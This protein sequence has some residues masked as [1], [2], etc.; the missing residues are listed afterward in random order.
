MKIN[1]RPEID[2]L[3]AIAVISVILFHAGSNLFSGGYVGVDIFFVISGFLITN[4]ILIELQKGNFSII[5]FYERRAR[6]ILPLLFFVMTLSIPFAW[7]LLP[8]SDLQNFSKSLIAATFFLSNLFFWKEGGGYFEIAS[9]LKPLVHT[10]S[11]AIEAQYYLFFPLLLIFIYKLGKKWVLFSIYLVIICSLL[12]AQVG[13]IYRPVANFFLLPTR[14]WEFAIGSLVV[15]LISNKHLIIFSSKLKSLL[16][17][18]GLLLII[19]AIFFFNKETAFT[20]FY[21][22]IPTIGAALIILFASQDNIVGRFLSEKKIVFIGLISYSLYIWHLPILAFSRYYFSS[23]NTTHTIVLIL[24]TFFLSAITWRFIERPFRNNN[25]FSRN[26]IFI[27]S[28]IVSVFFICFGFVSFKVFSSHSSFGLE[29][30][31]AKI[32]AEGNIVYAP[33]V[34]EREFIK[35]RIQFEKINPN[36]IVLGSSRTM[37]IGEHIYNDKVL[38][39]SV[40]GGSIEDHIAIAYMATKRF[41]LKTLIISADPWLFNSKSGQTRYK[42]LNDEYSAALSDF[43]F[44]TDKKTYSTTGILL[45]KNRHTSLELL[46]Y[47]IYDSVNSDNILAFN[48]LPEI[49]D[50]IRPD[51]SRVYNSEYT[52]KNEEHIRDGF[53]SILDYAMSNY[54]YSKDSEVMFGKFLDMYSKKYEFVLV[55]SP[56]HPYLYEEMRL[57]KPIFLQIEKNFRDFAKLHNVK[58]IGSYNPKIVGC[59]SVD[60]YDGMHPK[61]TCMKKVLKELDSIK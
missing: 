29:E 19:A 13:S 4:I 52:N 22:L 24:I 18:L 41:N 46:F 32:V 42:L 50:K 8:L 9:G 51:G 36:V 14:V 55:L 56:Y 45:K 12:T 17:G 21:T 43:N 11:L 53:K 31:V 23:I 35:S 26:F 20:S 30:K 39:L 10:W 27:F 2:G 34:N 28:A 47:K 16:S 59:T 40:S 37:Q 60:F 48:D 5:N 49:R 33:N 7:I 58:I 57:Q 6:R 25:I 1:Y 15:I 3:R 54:Q 44:A 38:N 61:D